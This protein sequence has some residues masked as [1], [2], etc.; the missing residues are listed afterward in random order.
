MRNGDDDIKNIV[1]A[2]APTGTFASVHME[3]RSDRDQKSMVTGSRGFVSV[4]DDLRQLTNCFFFIWN[5]TNSQPTSNTE[6]S[7]YMT[8]KTLPLG[9]QDREDVKTLADA[10]VSSSHITN[11][12]NDR[13]G[14]K[15]TPQQ[16]RNPI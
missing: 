4:K 12:L 3:S 7:T 6:A 11:F 2:F 1:P 15:V 13:I 8:T 5:Y 16:T 9:G 14:C 10:R